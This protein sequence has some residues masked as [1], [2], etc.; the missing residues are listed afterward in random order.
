MGDERRWGER[1]ERERGTHLSPCHANRGGRKSGTAAA[2]ATAVTRARAARA[3]TTTAGAAV[4]SK[5]EGETSLVGKG[6]NRYM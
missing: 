5:R 6:R 4:G 1:G 2:V 3:T